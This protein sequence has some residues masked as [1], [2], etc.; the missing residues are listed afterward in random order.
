MN[1]LKR[2]DLQQFVGKTMYVLCINKGILRHQQC[3]YWIAETDEDAKEYFNSVKENLPA[4]AEFSTVELEI[5]DITAF[6]LLFNTGNFPG[7]EIVKHGRVP[8]SELWVHDTKMTIKVRDAFWKNGGIYLAIGEDGK[9]VVEKIGN[10]HIINSFYSTPELAEVHGKP[11]YI[12]TIIMRKGMFPKDVF[13]NTLDGEVVY[14]YD[15][16]DGMMSALRHLH[17]DID[18]INELLENKELIILAANDGSGT[19]AQYLGYPVFFLSKEGALQF[20]A[21]NKEAFTSE[22]TTYSLEKPVEAISILTKDLQWED[23]YIM[24]DD[25][26]MHLCYINDIIGHYT[27]NKS[28]G[29]DMKFIKKAFNAPYMYITTSKK[30]NRKGKPYGYAIDENTTFLQVFYDKEFAKQYLDNENVPAEIGLIDNSKP[31]FNMKTLSL[32]AY[33]MQITSIEFVEADGDIVCVP[34]RQILDVMDIFDYSLSILVPT[35]V[36]SEPTIDFNP[37]EIVT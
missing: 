30:E 5:D 22:L 32:L 18:I 21:H 12:P 31:I 11:Q 28:F 23:S 3:A 35:N 27:G 10:S 34:I 36:N 26:T 17:T 9:P 7:F 16:Y 25:G 33:H 8:A 19:I 15:F 13:C 24:S 6:S 4:N 20:L 2:E 14:G 1:M 37:Y 29:C